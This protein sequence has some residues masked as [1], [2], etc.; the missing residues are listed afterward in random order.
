MLGHNLKTVNED[1]R[2]PLT[3]QGDLAPLATVQLT[4]SKGIPS[5]SQ[6][7]MPKG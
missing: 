3:E 6:S 1:E 2:R 4:A 5:E 7:K